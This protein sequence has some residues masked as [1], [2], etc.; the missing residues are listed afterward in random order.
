MFMFFPIARR[1]QPPNACRWLQYHDRDTGDLCGTLPLAIGMPVALTHHLNRSPGMMLLKGTKGRVHSW[2]WPDNDRLAHRPP[3]CVYVKFDGATWQ[4]DGIDEP[5]VYPIRLMKQDWFLDGKRKNPVLKVKRQQIPLTPAFAITAHSSQGKTLRALLLD[6][7]VEKRVDTTIGAVGASRVRSREDCLILR[8]FPLWLFQRGVSDGPRLLLQ[9]LRGEEVDLVAYAE[10]LH[11]HATCSHCLQVRHLDG[12]EHER[13]EKVRA[14]R[15]AM[16]MHCKHGNCGPRKRKLY[17][18]AMK[19]PCSACKLAKIEDAFPRAQL[20]QEG[21]K[22][23]LSC[24]RAAS[25]LQCTECGMAKGIEY[26]NSNMVTFPLEGIVC[27]SCQDTMEAKVDKKIRKNWFT[28]RGCK[29]IFPAA[30]SSKQSDHQHCLNCASRGAR[31][32]DEQTCR[33]CKRKWHEK[34]VKGKK[35]ARYCPGCRRK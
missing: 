25:Q 21:D 13:W 8:P 33:S 23:C 19:Y 28:C 14:N 10:G 27:R 26:F 1:S 30:A 16:C 17:T 6:L 9:K 29:Q 22:K 31:Q 3:R 32:K 11:P 24:C 18:G 12:F 4:L 2:E 20:R 34:Q 5:G 15:P 7:N 35:R